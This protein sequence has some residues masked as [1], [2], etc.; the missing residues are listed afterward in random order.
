MDLMTWKI[1]IPSCV[2][3]AS[4][5]LPIWTTSLGKFTLT[6]LG[7]I[8]H[9][10]IL[11]GIASRTHKLAIMTVTDDSWPSKCWTPTLRPCSPSEGGMPAL[12]ST[13][14]WLKIRQRELLSFSQPLSKCTKLCFLNFRSQLFSNFVQACDVLWLWWRGSWL[15][16]PWSQRRSRSHHRQG[17]FCPLDTG[18]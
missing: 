14:S 9:L 6:I 3:M 12:A 7:L 1:S 4:T 18:V 17:A 8:W 15:G 5:D 2:L 11:I 13:L 16:V 10:T